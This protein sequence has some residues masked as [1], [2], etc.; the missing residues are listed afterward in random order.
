MLADA[1]L[2]S[3]D[4]VF[5]CAD[6]DFDFNIP[7]AFERPTLKHHLHEHTLSY[8]RSTDPHFLCRVHFHVLVQCNLNVNHDCLPQLPPKIKDHHHL[9]Q[10]THYA[11]S[12]KDDAAEYC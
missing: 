9:H 7:C 6:C 3:I 8:I 10:L 1:C 11:S 5:R 2:K 4:A 12:I